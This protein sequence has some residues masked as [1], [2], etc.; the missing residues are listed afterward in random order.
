MLVTISTGNKSVKFNALLYSRSDSTILL[1]NISYRLNFKGKKQAITFVNAVNNVN[2]KLVIFLLSSKLHPEKIN[3]E[4]FMVVDELNLNLYEIKTTIQT[5]FD[6]LNDI[7][8]KNENLDT[9]ALLT[10]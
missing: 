6:H 1:K 7:T 9:V 4:K 10:H 8:L 5:Q 2:S 3:F